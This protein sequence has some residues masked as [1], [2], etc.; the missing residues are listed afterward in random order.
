M[1]LTIFDPEL[2]PEGKYATALVRAMTSAFR[3][4]PTQI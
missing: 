1:E 2:D 3:V 4:R